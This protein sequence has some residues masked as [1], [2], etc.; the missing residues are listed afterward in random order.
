MVELN[1]YLSTPMEYLALLD[2]F[3]RLYYVF[4]GVYLLRYLIQTL[5]ELYC[6]LQ[7]F[8]ARI[9]SR[10]RGKVSR[11][12]RTDPRNRHLQA[13]LLTLL[14]GDVGT[15][16]RL[17]SQQR[18]LNPGKSDNWYLEKVIWDLERDRH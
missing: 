17:L 3:V 5:Q 16:K 2:L 12:Y 6:W 15:A 4:A 13:D 11:S 9:D 7:G 1:I 14:K 8:A 18:R 10:P